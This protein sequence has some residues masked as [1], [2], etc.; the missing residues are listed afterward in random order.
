[1]VFTTMYNV[2]DSYF[3]GLISTDALAALTLSFQ[4]FF[5]L[6]TIG[7]GVNAA[8]GALV[9]F[10]HPVG[11]HMRQPRPPG[12]FSETPAEP[13]RTSPALGEHTDEVLRESGFDAAKIMELREAGVVRQGRSEQDLP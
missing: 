12:Q 9:E 11:G 10:D 7:F 2:V 1:M 6:V 8:M 4:I 3:A 5:M 13:F